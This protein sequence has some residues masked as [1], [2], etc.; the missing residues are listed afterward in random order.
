LQSNKSNA[1]QA[2]VLRHRLLIMLIALMQER[3]SAYALFNICYFLALS[4]KLLGLVCSNP[5]QG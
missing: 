5:R 2:K 1:A 4:K 3:E